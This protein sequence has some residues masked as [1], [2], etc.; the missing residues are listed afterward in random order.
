MVGSS[1]DEHSFDLEM[2]IS[3]FESAT[4]LSTRQMACK[5]PSPRQLEKF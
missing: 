1:A 3:G 4:L 5:Y 2:M